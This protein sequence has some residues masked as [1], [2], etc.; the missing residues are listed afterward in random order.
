MI[1]RDSGNQETQKLA[2]V[3]D[4]LSDVDEGSAAFLRDEE[5]APGRVVQQ[6][7]FLHGL[8]DARIATPIGDADVEVGALARDPIDPKIGVHEGDHRNLRNA[9]Q[10]RKQR[11]LK[12]AAVV[13]VHP[14]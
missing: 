5:L 12:I 13:H 10:R 4:R 3:T 11:V 7:L 6:A 14:A 2:V 9:G 1:D 8:L